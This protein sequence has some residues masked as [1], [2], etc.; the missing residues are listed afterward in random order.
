M[1]GQEFCPLMLKTGKMLMNISVIFENQIFFIKNFNNIRQLG[2]CLSD[3]FPIS[4]SSYLIKLLFPDQ[5][6]KVWL[7]F[8]PTVPDNTTLWS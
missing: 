1:I 2:L 5:D 3:P 4:S 7:Y 8:N 6:N